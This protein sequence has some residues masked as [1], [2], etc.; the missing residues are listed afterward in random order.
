MI[1]DG[2]STE[3]NIVTANIIGNNHIA[4]YPNPFVSQLVLSNMK[5]ISQISI[6]NMEGKLMYTENVNGATIKSINAAWLPEGIYIVSFFNENGMNV[7]RTKII[8]ASK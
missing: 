2:T 5:S 4:V 3:S 7:S 6:Y 8:K 1:G